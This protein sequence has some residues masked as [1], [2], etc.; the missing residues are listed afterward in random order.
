MWE[1]LIGD[2]IY[3]SWSLRGWLL[4]EAFGTPVKVTQAPMF[5]EALAAHLA[6]FGSGSGLV[7][8]MR[9]DGVVI[10]DTL[11]MAE[12]LAE[13]VPGMWPAAAADRARARAMVAE[14]HSGFTALRSACPMNMRHVYEGFEPDDAVRRDLDRVEALWS[15]AP[16][17]LFGDYSIADVFY[18]PVA[19][20]IAGYGLEV[21]AEAQA[22][23]ERHLAH[24]AVRRWRAMGIAEH[25]VQPG[26]DLDLPTHD[27]PGTRRPARVA[28]NG[29]A[30]NETCPFSG[31]P[32]APD[33]LA[34]VDGRVIG[35]C[36][37]FCRDKV[38]ADA[39]AWSAVRPLLT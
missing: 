22:Y 19:M 27:W 21:G 36:N 32:V 2:R 14:M 34:E 3:S 12:T 39:E 8:Q 20:R 30:V 37:S 10:W 29:P 35:F 5:S 31:R 15:G 7:P 17:W 1:L 24:K 16:G 26:Y 4:F 18:A 11:A 25:S 6:D 28:T 9:R 33:G 38:I 13:E 23:V